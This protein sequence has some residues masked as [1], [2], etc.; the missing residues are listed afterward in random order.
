VLVGGYDWID[1]SDPTPA[2]TF[3]G[4]QREGRA[5]CPDPSDAYEVWRMVDGKIVRT[6]TSFG[7]DD[8]AEP[9]T[10]V[11]DTVTGKRY[12]LN[13]GLQMGRCHG[14]PRMPFAFEWQRGR[15]VESY[16]GELRNSLYEQCIS[17]DDGFS[18]PGIASLSPGKENL[19]EPPSLFRGVRMESLL[20]D[21]PKESVL[22]SESLHA[23]YVASVLAFDRKTVKQFHAQGI[24]AMATAKAISAIDQSS[25]TLAEKRKRI[26]VLFY[27]HKRLAQAFDQAWPQQLLVWL[28]YEDWKPVFKAIS[29]FGPR[30]YA[31]ADQLRA[32]AQEAGMDALACDI[33]NARGWLC[34]ETVGTDD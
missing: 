17:A 28:P 25:L 13:D 11:R 9:L 2:D 33:D 15:L 22:D 21:K 26:A 3:D 24:S 7:H 23:S 19:S 32:A 4:W 16:P 12:Y 20:R 18:C 30:G 10:L 1:T 29:V 27:D 6:T 31:Q 5:S 34:G 14:G 8:T